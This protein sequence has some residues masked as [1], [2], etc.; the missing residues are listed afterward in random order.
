M[1]FTGNSVGA[2]LPRLTAGTLMLSLALTW[3]RMSVSSALP[4]AVLPGLMVR[5]PPGVDTSTEKNDW[6]GGGVGQLMVG[7]VVSLTT[8]MSTLAIA[9]AAPKASTTS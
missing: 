6:P 7:G 9:L 8:V 5:A 2:L 1:A 4:P 3:R